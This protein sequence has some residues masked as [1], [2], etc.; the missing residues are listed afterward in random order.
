M[1]TDTLRPIINDAVYDYL[2][3][4]GTTINADADGLINAIHTAVQAHLT[5]TIAG[6]I[7]QAMKTP[8]VIAVI[9][10]D[11]VV[12]ILTE[13]EDV[14]DDDYDDPATPVGYRPGLR[15]AARTIRQARREATK[16]ATDNTP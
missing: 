16:E 4:L 8:K 1:V 3:H 14:L 6:A 12:P 13:L 2:I 7:E 15:R 5:K 11:I 10:K 9:T